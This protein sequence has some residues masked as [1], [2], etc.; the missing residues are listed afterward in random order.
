MAGPGRVSA[1]SRGGN[2]RPGR[3]CTHNALSNIPCRD[4]F[5][6]ENEVLAGRG[7]PRTYMTDNMAALWPAPKAGALKLMFWQGGT[8]MLLNMVM[9]CVEFCVYSFDSMCLCLREGYMLTDIFVY[10]C[11][12]SN[13][14]IVTGDDFFICVI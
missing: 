5:D 4:A 7:S 13:Y 11:E 2:P 6:T 8:M 9:I 3:S 10:N 14:N 12:N 1:P